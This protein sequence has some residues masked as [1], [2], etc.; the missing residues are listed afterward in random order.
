MKWPL[1][2]TQAKS[3]GV[4]HNPHDLSFSSFATATELTGTAH[5]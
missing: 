1:Y 4:A 3:D 2:T 5:G